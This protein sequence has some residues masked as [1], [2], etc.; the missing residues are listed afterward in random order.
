MR[1]VSN[2]QSTTV[3]G[4]KVYTSPSKNKKKQKTKNNSNPSK[5]QTQK[6]IIQGLYIKHTNF[7]NTAEPEQDRDDRFLHIWVISKI[8]HNKVVLLLNSKKLLLEQKCLTDFTILILE[9][10]MF[11]KTA[12]TA[13]GLPT[14]VCKNK[15]S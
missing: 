6:Y 11:R 14:P 12:S 15:I 5:T 8:F 9:P 13:W 3:L 1:L 2:S 7:K 4:L 10:L